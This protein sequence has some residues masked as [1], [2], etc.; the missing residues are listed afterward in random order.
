MDEIDEYFTI[1]DLVNKE[2]IEIQNIYLLTEKD[3][4]TLAV[5]WCESG[6]IYFKMFKK[7]NISNIKYFS[8]FLLEYDPKWYKLVI[9]WVAKPSIPLYLKPL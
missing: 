2:N 7:Q 4:F 3:K 5:R 6:D 8:T 1:K 9:D